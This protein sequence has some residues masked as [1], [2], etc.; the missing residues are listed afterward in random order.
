MTNFKNYMI[1]EDEQIGYGN[2][3][4]NL[5]E[6]IDSL[7]GVD[8][9]DD[10]H[11]IIDNIVSNGI[12][13][14]LSLEDVDFSI[15]TEQYFMNIVHMLGL[16]LDESLTV[17]PRKVNFGRKRSQ[18]SRLTGSDKMK[19]LKRL[20]ARRKMYHTN[21]SLRTKVK[22]QSIKYKRTSHAKFIHK[23]YNQLHKG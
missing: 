13:L 14:L 10:S 23:K 5:G 16:N 2:F 6:F 8:L 4:T 18:A 15:Q 3:F 7:Q 17:Q 20:K 22:K 11:N 1:S 12:D 9:P 21:A 19:Y